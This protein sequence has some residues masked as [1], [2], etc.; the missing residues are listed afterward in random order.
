MYKLKSSSQPKKR[1]KTSSNRSRKRKSEEMEESFDPTLEKE[2]KD[3]FKVKVPRTIERYIDKH[4]CRPLS[5]EER[6]AMLEASKTG[7][8]GCNAT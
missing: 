7:H 1:Q 3:D 4:F 8:R 5:K 6:T 2:D